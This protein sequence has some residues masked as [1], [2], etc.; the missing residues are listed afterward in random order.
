MSMTALIK[1]IA[2]VFCDK[3]ND[4]RVTLPNNNAILWFLSMRLKWIYK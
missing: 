4:V 2:H 3:P 1:Q